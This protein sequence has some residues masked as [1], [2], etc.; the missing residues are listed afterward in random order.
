VI[1]LNGK[2]LDPDVIRHAYARGQETI[3]RHKVEPMG[4]FVGR[5][6]RTFGPDAI[7]RLADAQGGVMAWTAEGLT[8][9]LRQ[10]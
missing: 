2:R 4:A 9:P 1:A 8:M 5:A 10:P 7:I 3:D 6:C